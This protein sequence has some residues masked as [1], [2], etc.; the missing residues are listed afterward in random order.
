MVE[1]RD[2]SGEQ[3]YE[4]KLVVEARLVN[5][6]RSWIWLHPEAFRVAYP[7]RL[8][9]NLYL[10]T[11]EL[12]HFN[13][14]LAG[15]AERRKLRLRWYGESE[16][17]TVQTAVMELKIKNGQLGDKR[18]W[19]LP[20]PLPLD[21]PYADLL[22]QV[23]LTAPPF[24]QPWLNQN[25]QPTLINR[26]ERAYYATPDGQLRLTLDFN[27]RFFDQRLSQRPNLD[28]PLP[29]TGA[30]VIEIKAPPA[31]GRRLE[32]A[33]GYFPLLRSRNSKYVIG[34]AGGSL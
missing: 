9:N 26:Y 21:Q 13:A 10:D 19:P 23:R 4:L 24:W 32:Q 34:V 20:E 11:V 1:G 6:A 14:N 25:T 33:M 7:P 15:T 12:S 8:V 16:P 5:Q 28:W 22:R 31:Y 2:L 17:A 30:A 27:Q 18:R 3:R 29:G